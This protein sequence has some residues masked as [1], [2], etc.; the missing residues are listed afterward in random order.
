M[1]YTHVGRLGLVVSRLCL[2]TMNFGP[3]TSREDS[4]AVMDHAHETGHGADEFSGHATHVMIV[5]LHPVP[6]LPGF[7]AYEHKKRAVG[8]DHEQR[9]LT[10]LG[11]GFEGAAAQCRAVT[12]NDGAEV[13]LR[14][15]KLLAGFDERPRQDLRGAEIGSVGHGV[16]GQYRGSALHAH[17]LC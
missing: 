15:A 3:V 13:H 7:T 16:G 6:H 2:G 17:I 11:I 5:G 10:R 1:E 4:F 14:E 8:A 12:A 9:E